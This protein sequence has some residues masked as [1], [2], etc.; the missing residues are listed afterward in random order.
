MRASSYQNLIDGLDK[1]DAPPEIKRQFEEMLRR[2][3]VID[4][5]VISDRNDRV[6]FASHLLGLREARSVIR[7]RLMM[8]FQI[9][10]AQAY[11]DISEAMQSVQKTAQKL[12]ADKSQSS[13]S[14]LAHEG[15]KE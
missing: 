4:G 13:Q 15:R 7:D 14:I 2:N 3:A 1:I 10:R 6:R 11:A 9:S 8:R 12:D 5:V